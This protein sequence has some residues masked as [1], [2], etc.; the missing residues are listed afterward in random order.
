MANRKRF[1]TFL[2]FLILAAGSLVSAQEHKFNQK[3]SWVADKNAFSYKVELRGVDSDFKLTQET[4]TTYID[5]SLPAGQFKYRVYAYD[6]LG[7]QASVSE[8]RNFKVIKAV[9]PKVTNAEKTVVPVKEESEVKIPV[10]VASIEKDST[11]ELVN[12][13]TKEVV[14]GK[15]DIQTNEKQELV[16]SKAVFPPVKE[17]NWVVK[18]TNPSGLYTESEEIKVEP[19]ITQA[20][21]EAARKAEEKRL[22]EEE[23]RKRREEERLAA[24]RK[25]D[26]DRLAAERRA[27]EERIAAE[28]KAEE[29]RLA[30]EA[31][32]L[33][34]ERKAEEE[35]L[36]AEQREAEKRL[37]AEQ[38]ETEARLAAEQKAAEERL[39]AEQREAEARL[40]AEQKE[41]EKRLAAEQKA[42]EEQLK[43]EKK[44]AEERLAAE[45]KAA[46]EQEKL[47]KAQAKAD[48][49]ELKRQKPVKDFTLLFGGSCYKNFYNTAFD[50][51]NIS[52]G[53]G[54]QQYI[55]YLPGINLQMG[56]LPVKNKVIKTGFEL[57]T[58]ATF[59]FIKNDYITA[60]F[61]MELFQLNYVLQFRIVKDVFLLSLK[62]GGSVFM[63]EEAVVYSKK[64]DKFDMNAITGTIGPGV[65]GGVGLVLIPTRNF[66]MELG[67]QFTH[68][69]I[70]QQMAGYGQA[71]FVMGVRL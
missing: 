27:E 34:A 43:A 54:I 25:A 3:L 65:Q 45:K 48:E 11:V 13:E 21:I 69:F 9:S 71:Y 33:A 15:L 24:E 68:L 50:S 32:R 37:A 5:V 44:E 56:I 66:E 51:L 31:E 62:G 40:A 35:R 64:A 26:E 4:D 18:V 46:Q 52:Q 55:D 14:K 70:A 61:P 10:N 16:A 39:K 12:K 60:Y 29:D 28:K 2:L 58:T 6:F 19:K 1:L 22:A 30:A 20:E 53:T 63:I 38:K 36:A 23:A 49:K 47:A 8:W 57:N 7:R 41:A 59:S 42:A 17:G 67:A